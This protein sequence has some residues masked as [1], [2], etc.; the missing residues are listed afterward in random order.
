MLQM[1]ARK[2]KRGKHLFAFSAC[3]LNRQQSGRGILNKAG[4]V[5][6]DGSIL[7]QGG[8]ARFVSEKKNGFA[9][10]RL[11]LSGPVD[12]HGDLRM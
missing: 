7:G 10:P 12:E 2:R 8:S 9:S 6:N 11:L 4:P 3:K 1:K 5:D